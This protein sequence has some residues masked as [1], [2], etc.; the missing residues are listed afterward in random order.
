[1]PSD[2]ALALANPVTA[3]TDR[4]AMDVALMLEG[5]GATLEEVL[6]LHDVSMDRMVRFNKDAIFLQKVRALREEVHEKGLT[7]RTKARAQAEELLATSWGIIHS[8]DV[9]ANVKADLIKA[10]VKWAGL[11]PK[12]TQIADG[13]LAGGVSITINLDPMGK[14]QSAVSA[15]VTDAEL[16]E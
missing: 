16:V 1:M 3:W 8:P 9:S 6:G 4:L 13:S 2:Q 5:S 12:E 15:N 10:T 14:P 11:E 7:F